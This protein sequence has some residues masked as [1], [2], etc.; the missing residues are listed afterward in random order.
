VPFILE[1]RGS[2]DVGNADL[3][4]LRRLRA[5]AQSEGAA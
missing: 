1:T 4:A 2:R 3:A 5:E